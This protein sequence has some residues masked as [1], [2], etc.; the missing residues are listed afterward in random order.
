VFI[1][2]VIITA[3]FVKLFIKAEKLNDLT[4]RYLAD[5]GVLVFAYEDVVS[6]LTSLVRKQE[7]SKIRHIARSLYWVVVL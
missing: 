3:D 5:L 7:S 2:Y 6:H 4:Q 1:S